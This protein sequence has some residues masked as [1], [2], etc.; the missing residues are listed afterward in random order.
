MLR[1]PHAHT[2]SSVSLR[3]RKKHAGWVT[4]TLQTVSAFFDFTLP[5]AA[6]ALGLSPTSMKNV[7][8]RLGIPRWPYSRK[9]AR[10][11]TSSSAHG[12]HSS[13]SASHSRDD[14]PPPTQDSSHADLWFLAA[15]HHFDEGTDF[16]FLL[17]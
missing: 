15:G 12:E 16:S 13:T 4:I 6:H 9:L 14:P 11:S 8:R 17:A 7:C 2:S 1:D 10:A 5:D 3:P